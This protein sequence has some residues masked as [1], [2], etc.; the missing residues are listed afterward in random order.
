MLKDLGRH[1]VDE[2]PDSLVGSIRR[3]EKRNPQYPHVLERIDYVY[4]GGPYFYI[5]EYFIPDQDAKKEVVTVGRMRFRI[6][7][8]Y[9]HRGAY[10]V[11]IDGRLAVAIYWL[12]RMTKIFGLIYRR[13]ILTAA[14]WNLATYQEGHIIS[15][16]DLKWFRGRDDG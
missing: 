16:R 4:E 6:M 7:G 1:L 2:P 15:W 11:R 14:V 3:D 9:P 10:L 12:R 13:L 5:A 8:F